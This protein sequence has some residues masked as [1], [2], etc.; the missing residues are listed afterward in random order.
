MTVREFDPE[1]LRGALEI[2]EKAAELGTWDQ[3][4]WFV[5]TGCGTACCFAGNYALSQGCTPVFHDD[6][7]VSGSVT[8]PEGRKAFVGEWVEGHLGLTEDEA[9]DLFDQSNTLN[10]L[11]LIVEEIIESRAGQR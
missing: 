10:D 11:R 4:Q 2:T 8:T 5:E 9:L 3:R 7:H 6:L 1:R